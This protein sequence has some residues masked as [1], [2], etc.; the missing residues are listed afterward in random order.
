M[1]FATA[2]LVNLFICTLAFGQAD[3]AKLRSDIYNAHTDSLKM[4][5]YRQMVRYYTFINDDSAIHYAQKGIEQFSSNKYDLGKATMINLLGGIYIN[6]GLFDVALQK[7]EE[8]LKIFRALDNKKGIANAQNSIGVVEGRKSNY[9]KAIEYFINSLAIFESIHDTDG[10]I[11]TY[12]KLGAANDFCRNFDKSLAYYNSALSISKK[13]ISPYNTIYIYSNIGSLY[14]RKNEFDTAKVYLQK[15]LDLSTDP[16]F[17]KLRIS[18]LTNL[19]NIYRDGNQ[20]E[21]ALKYFGEA[22]KIAKEQQQSEE[23]I[24]LLLDIAE[25]T[26]KKEPAKAFASLQEALKNTR[27]AGLRSL[28]ADVMDGIINVQVL[29]ND[30]KEAFHWLLRKQELLDSIYDINK[31]KE[32][33]NI[34]AVYELNKSNE[35]ITALKASELRNE[36]KR[37]III[38]IAFFLGASVLAVLLLYRNSRKLNVQ[39]AKKTDE[40]KNANDVKDKFFSIVGHDLNNAVVNM[41]VLLALYRSPNT[42]EED[43]R[44]ILESLDETAQISGEIL[45]NLLNWGKSRIKGITLKQD[46][47]DA[48]EIIRNKVHLMRL[49]IKNK[50]VAVVTHIPAETKIYGDINHFT[51]VVRN[52]LSNAIKYTKADGMIEVGAGRADTPGFVL[53]SVKDNGIGMTSAQVKSIFDPFNVSAPGTSNEAGNS[54][55]LLLC[56]EFVEANGGKIWAESEPGKGSTFYFTFK[57][58]S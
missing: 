17:A 21:M 24:R 32:I 22:E 18:P 53:F 25:I 23:Y 41:P 30:Y 48:M 54:I 57:L 34:Q 40:L 42:T 2:F 37:N 39:L 5:A 56:K 10:I 50:N 44:A 36:K 16:M 14:C 7:E 8:A 20:D 38:I 46:N 19:G 58:H 45:E 11:N 9:K 28:E 12:I 55:G 43:K 27:E 3:V 4:A 26:T 6:E 15:A 52:L 1:R 13:N 49:A 31:Q 51:F 29:D 35:Q 47:F 33:A